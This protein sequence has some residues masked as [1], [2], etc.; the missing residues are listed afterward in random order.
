MARRGWTLVMVRDFTYDYVC[1]YTKDL[2]LYFYKIDEVRRVE[3]VV[4]V[5]TWY[6]FV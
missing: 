4:L 2:Y 6:V 1:M 3:M 5:K